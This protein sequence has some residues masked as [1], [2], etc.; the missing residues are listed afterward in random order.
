MSVFWELFAETGNIDY[1]LL[2][3]QS[4]NMAAQSSKESDET[5]TTAE[6]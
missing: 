5:V 4:G 1:Y 3:L 2:Y 6:C